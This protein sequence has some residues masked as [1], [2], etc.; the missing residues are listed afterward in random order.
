MLRHARLFD[1]AKEILVYPPISPMASTKPVPEIHQRLPSRA[2]YLVHVEL[3]KMPGQIR[4]LETPNTTVNDV[5]VGIVSGCYTNIEL[6]FECLKDVV[7]Y[8]EVS[9][10]YEYVISNLERHLFQP[11]NLTTHHVVVPLRL[12]VDGEERDPFNALYWESWT[13]SN[14]IEHDTAFAIRE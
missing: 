14:V 10:K 2:S 9:V 6:R 12:F 11:L 3:N 8:D 7:L 13:I 4:V 1:R 5:P